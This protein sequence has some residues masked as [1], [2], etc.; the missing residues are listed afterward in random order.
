MDV[1]LLERIE[2]LGQMGDVVKVTPGFARNYLI[3]YKKALRAT[4]ENTKY[5]GTQKKEL[6]AK[7]LESKKEAQNVADKMKDM[8]LI[9]IRQAGDTGRLY[10]S[11]TTKDIA[12][13]LKNKGINI[14]FH[15]VAISNPIK[16]IGIYN[17]KITL[18]PE[19][20]IEIE[21]IV[22]RSE[23]EAQSLKEK[24]IDEN[25]K[26]KNK[27]KKYNEENINTDKNADKKEVKSNDE[28]T[29]TQSENNDDKK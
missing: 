11:V 4:K 2:K 14:N 16:E 29:D 23:D 9:V 6:E 1:I 5:F 22:A 20:S 18:H 26:E 13:L 27:K 24:Q 17:I 15:Q 19:I 25:N 10:G 7:N 28:K 21:N 12:K 3:P 8:S